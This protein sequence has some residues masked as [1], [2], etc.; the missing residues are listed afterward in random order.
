MKRPRKRAQ[1]KQQQ[2]SKK[3]KRS[4]ATAG[5]SGGRG[6]Y[7]QSGRG[8]GPSKPQVPVR[9]TIQKNPKGFGFVIPENRTL[10]DAYV[11]NQQAA[12]LLNGD[13][14]L[15]TYIDS[16]GK[17]AARIKEIQERGKKKVL[18]QI[19]GSGHAARL[20]TKDSEWKV[21]ASDAEDGSW[22]MGNI[23]QYPTPDKLG[24]VSVAKD[25]GDKLTPAQDIEIAI[26]EFNLPSDFPISV[27]AEILE[28][29]KF[30]QDEEEK[31]RRRDLTEIPLVTI[32]GEDAKDFDDA[33]AVVTGQGEKAFILYVAIADVSAYVTPGSA[34]D[35]AAQ[36][37]GTSVYF[38]GTC[39]PMLPEPISNDMCSL[40]PKEDRYA[41]TAEITYDREGEVISSDFYES[42]IRTHARVT[43][44]ELEA[45]FE[46]DDAML[47][48]YAFLEK[49]FKNLRAL[50]RL[51]AKQRKRRGTL[52]FDLPESKM[53]L[54]GTGMPV[55]IFPAPRFESHK[56][57]EEFMI[58][59]NREVAQVLRETNTKSVYRVH[60]SPDP[61]A[62]D[63]INAALKTL[64][65]S[66]RLERNTPTDFARV[67][68]AT[69]DIKGGK[70]LHSLILRSQK[71]AIYDAEPRGH[72]GLSL[73]DYTHF[74]S[75]IRRY[76][77]LVVHRSLKKF[78][79]QERSSDKR[80]EEDPLA[81]VAE[82]CSNQE[83][84]AVEAERFVTRRKQCWFMR[85]RLDESFDA[86]ITW[87]TNEG[88]YLR[89]PQFGIEGF[90]EL[91]SMKDYYLFDEHTQTLRKEHG[92]GTLHVGDKLSV[93]VE[94][95]SID[96]G[97]IW[98]TQRL[99]RN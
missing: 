85:E 10:P 32:D 54:D 82:R 69:M 90:L 22:V 78:I 63:E 72:F 77:D 57:I 94:E 79:G 89:I 6:D 50:Y 96:R 49:P 8:A 48:K 18:G 76:P 7:R 12:A 84:R 27:K 51:L 43:Y 23:E 3:P 31:K 65:T 5:K 61:D 47:G 62:L 68:A 80:N 99:Q 35:K 20:V 38:P 2:R 75:P 81:A 36:L 83:R 1:S 46:R 88:S 53:E 25:Y 92:K 41:L 93:R 64:G 40:R 67:L 87:M 74:T 29:R 60:D 98:F 4:G 66:V 24:E 95:V 33:V 28:S 97:K 13:K 71:Q 56:V 15:F 34:L 16:R 30:S 59:A 70:S 73:R 14:V 37:R 45:Y 42:L 9:G 44:T 91:N 86:E 17:K 55:R 19:L 39:V 11:D 58:A 26:S 52:E 21:K